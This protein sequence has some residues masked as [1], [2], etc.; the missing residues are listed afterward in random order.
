MKNK[1]MQRAKKTVK[2]LRKMRE[3]C[4]SSYCK[5][6]PFARKK[7]AKGVCSLKT[8]LAG[9]APLHWCVETLEKKLEEIED[10][11]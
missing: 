4:A 11:G 8:E 2:M 1:K 9:Q 6:C 10:E 3:M 7:G 5:D